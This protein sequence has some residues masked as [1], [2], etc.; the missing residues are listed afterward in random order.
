MKSASTQL[1]K[2]APKAQPLRRRSLCR[3]CYFTT[4]L[5][6]YLRGA[7]ATDYCK[8]DDTLPH[9][10]KASPIF[11]RLAPILY[12]YYSPVLSRLRQLVSMSARSSRLRPPPQRRLIHLCRHYAILIP[13]DGAIAADFARRTA[14]MTQ[15]LPC[16]PA[17]RLGPTGRDTDRAR[18]VAMR[19]FLPPFR[20]GYRT[21]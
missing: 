2:S 3:Q 15:R 4:Q 9:S 11:R 21:G 18:A 7:H 6:A 20:T 13:G 10:I 1:A 8:R 16:P 14:T 17:R 12:L 5:D 19:L